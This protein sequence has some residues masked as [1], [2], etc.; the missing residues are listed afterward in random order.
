MK[1]CDAEQ[2]RERDPTHAFQGCVEHM[3][4]GWQRQL[5][6]ARDDLAH[7]PGDA[8]RADNQP[9]YERQRVKSATG[10]GS[11]PWR[12][13][14]LKRKAALRPILRRSSRPP[15]ALFPLGGGQYGRRPRAKIKRR[16]RES[17][18]GH[19]GREPGV[20]IAG[21]AF[22]WARALTAPASPLTRPRPAAKTDIRACAARRS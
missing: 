18:W 6:D 12:M 7:E 2:V 3:S 21:Y 10:G 14:S 9:R 5:H 17:M 15:R 4:Q 11:A 1:R 19:D 22:P 16:A 8:A 20:E 13:R